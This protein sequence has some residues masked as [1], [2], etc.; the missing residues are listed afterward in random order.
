[1]FPH[2]LFAFPLNSYFHEER[3]QII[4]FNQQLSQWFTLSCPHKYVRTDD[5]TYWKKK[6][7]KGKKSICSGG[8]QHQRTGKLP[9]I[10]SPQCLFANVFNE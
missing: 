3:A 9:E 8:V 10:I 7:R 4:L 5:G 6:K 2:S 1:M